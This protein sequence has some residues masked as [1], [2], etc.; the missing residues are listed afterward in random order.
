MR[1]AS[2]VSLRAKGTILEDPARLDNFQPTNPA[3][4]AGFNIVDI[5][6]WKTVFYHDQPMLDPKLIKS[7]SDIGSGSELEVVYT[8]SAAGLVKSAPPA[9]DIPRQVLGDYTL[10]I[11]GYVD[12]IDLTVTG[13]LII[14]QVTSNPG[15]TMRFSSGSGIVI[16]TPLSVGDGTVILETDGSLSVN[17]LITASEVVIEAGRATQPVTVDAD[18]L[19]FSVLDAGQHLVINESNSVTLGSGSM[20][21]GNVTI[22]AGSNLVLDGLINDVQ[23][24]TLSVGSSLANRPGSGLEVAGNLFLSGPSIDLGGQDGDTMNF[25]SL[26][27]STTGTAKVSEDG[28]MSLAGPTSAAGL[29]LAASGT[30]S[31][32]NA[33]VG[34][35]GDAQLTAASVSVGENSTAVWNVAGRITL[36]A[37]DGGSVRVRGGANVAFGSVAFKTTGSVDIFEQSGLQLSGSSTA[38]A[39][40]LNSATD[41]TDDLASV[42]VSGSAHLTAPSLSLLDESN[43]SLSVAGNMLFESSTGGRVHGQRSGICSIWQPHH[44][45]GRQRA[46]LRRRGDDA[47]R[48][49]YRR[50]SRALRQRVAYRRTWRCLGNRRCGLRR[51]YYPAGK[52]RRRTA[53]DRRQHAV[54]VHRWRNHG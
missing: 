32:A 22:H 29:I 2:K 52:C 42:T 45:N 44:S 51:E 34:V 25:G 54:D 35:S 12:D 14:N 17:S 21:G 6:A 43:E 38:G 3:A 7:D 37:V 24:V 20:N 16:N 4:Q 41:I 9:V 15:Q 23:D 40:I 11:L 33:S 19:T 1:A 39:L 8:A 48:L 47:G 26:R 18:R 5:V 49:K 53:A 28:D 46:D 30:I 27:I 31:D 13:T 50:N 36:N 10:S